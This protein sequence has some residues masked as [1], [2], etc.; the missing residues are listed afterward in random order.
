MLLLTH[1]IEI[2]PF[3]M[4][5]DE[6]CPLLYNAQSYNTDIAISPMNCGV[7]DSIA[8]DIH[9]LPMRCNVT[10]LPHMTLHLE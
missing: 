1:T 10:N 3:D 7:T 4:T 6:K 2:Y 9:I 5:G 8:Y